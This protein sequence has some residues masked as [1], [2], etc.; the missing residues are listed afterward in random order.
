[1]VEERSGSETG[2]T[3]ADGRERTLDPASVAVQRIGGAISASVLSFVLLIG[4]ISFLA[5][6]RVGLFVGLLAV[7]IW[8]VVTG[9]T[10]LLAFIWPPVRFRHTAYSIDG[11]GMQIRRGVFWK[12]VVN[13]PRSRV[14]HTDVQQGPVERSFG[15]ATLII[16]TAG[17]QH[18]S[19]P[20]SGLARETALRIRDHLLT[21]DEDDDG[22]SGKR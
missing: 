11:R 18:A 15:L 5:A 8:G 4:T 13:V 9:G 22:R 16:Y 1:V 12:S 6:T 20:L 17:T 7:A 2:T 21:D 10:G 3:V 19:I 14:Q